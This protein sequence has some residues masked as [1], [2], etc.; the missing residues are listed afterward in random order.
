MS[1]PQRG[2]H[3]YLPAIGCPRHHARLLVRFIVERRVKRGS[4]VR[5]GKIRPPAAL[6]RADSLDWLQSCC[7]MLVMIYV[8]DMPQHHRFVGAIEK[9]SFVLKRTTRSASPSDISMDVQSDDARSSL[10]L[11]QQPGYLDDTH[12]NSRLLPQLGCP[13]SEGQIP[14]NDD[15]RSLGVHSGRRYFETMPLIAVSISLLCFF[16]SI[17]I[18]TPTLKLAWLLEYNGQIIVIGFLLGVMNLCTTTVVPHV[19]LLIEARF[20]ISSLQ[21]YEGLLTNRPLS[22]RLSLYWR[23]TLALLL[24]LP[25]GLAVAYK[26]F[27]GGLST[28]QIA[29]FPPLEVSQSV[30]TDPKDWGQQE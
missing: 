7:L 1:S 20:G 13:S 26:R 14:E 21:N 3:R 11:P 28:I 23:L 19:L 9:P 16:V 12:L 22:P 5:A 25:L 6:H 2:A 18:I 17:L 30:S 4:I 8:A 27:I 15:I 10:Q 29:P 24:A